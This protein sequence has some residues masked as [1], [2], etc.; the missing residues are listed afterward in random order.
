M[1]RPHLFLYFAASVLIAQPLRQLSDQ[2]GIRLGTAAEPSHF[3]EAP[4]ADTLAREFSQIEPENVMKFGPIH[5]GPA[6]YNF[7][8]A[9]ALVSFGLGHNMAVRGHTLVWHNQLP[10]WV[11]SGNYSTTQL[12]GILHDHISAVI[13]RY[14]GQVYAWDVINEAFNDDGTLRG[15]IWLDSPGIGMQ[16]T[17]Y[18]EQSLRWAHEADP[19]AL[20]FYND[21]SAESV[22]TKS[23]AIYK[24]AQDFVARGVPLHGIGMQMHFTTNNGSLASIESNLKRITDL[25][26]QVHITELD[27]RLPVDSSGNASPA[28]L[29]AQAQVYHDVFTLCLKFPLCA[30]IQS[31]GFTDKYSWIPGAFPGRGAALEFDASYQPK[32]AYQSIQMALQASPPVISADGLTN[33]ASYAKNAVAP[34]EIVVLFGATF[35]PASLALSQAGADGRIPSQLSDARLLFDGVPA[36]MLY[37]R[38]GQT[39]AVVPFAVGNQAATK[40]EYE[41]KGVRSN[42]V[43]MNVVRTMPGLFTLDSSGQGAGAILDASFRPISQ[44]NPARI[45]DVILL[46]GT[47]GGLTT[48]VSMDGE[49]PVVAPFPLVAAAVSA[50]IGG[51]D[52]PVQYSGGASGL[53]AGVIQVN[54]QLARG[55]ASGEQPIALKIGD[56]T[57]QSGVTVWV[58]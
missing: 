16:G 42:A 38:V 13:G 31:W 53:V 49:I 46:Y 19:Q 14:A 2:R 20:L 25:G 37:A 7:G 12:S 58:Q 24:M 17:G 48:P 28:D 36:P 10:S 3:S 56:A 44:I 43:T 34:G 50:K 9:D 39:A 33:G 11:T 18:M 30:A 35:G 54:V 52:C 21:Y 26:L 55:I 29:A 40:V 47:G 51:V 32:P 8:P 23:N 15:T 5:P 1:S 27:V 45:G 57:S 22:N 41:Y 6:T 4:Y